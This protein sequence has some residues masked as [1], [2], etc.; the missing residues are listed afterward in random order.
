MEY[1]SIASKNAPSN[2]VYFTD[3]FPTK[4]KYCAL[5]CKMLI[6][7]KIIEFLFYQ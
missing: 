3:L 2:I 6:H 7:K 5:K 4:H 1:T